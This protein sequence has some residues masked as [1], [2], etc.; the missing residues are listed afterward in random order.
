MIKLKFSLQ[1]TIPYNLQDKFK[2]LKKRQ[3][4]RSFQSNRNTVQTNILITCMLYQ[5]YSQYV[6]IKN[7]SKRV[8]N[9]NSKCKQ[10]V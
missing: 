9:I 2:Q 10:T 6:L 5:I 3:T 1:K 7:M 8:A 4:M